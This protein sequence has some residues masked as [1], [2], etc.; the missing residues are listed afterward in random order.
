M[1]SA[2][3][4]RKQVVSQHAVGNQAGGVWCR[5]IFLSKLSRYLKVKLCNHRMLNG[6]F[7]VPGVSQERAVRAE[8]FLFLD[9]VL[10]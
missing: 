5:V 7:T 10:G 3:T 8:C 6:R 9:S 2:M 4:C 1:F